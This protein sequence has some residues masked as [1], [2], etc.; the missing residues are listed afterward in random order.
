MRIVS[1]RDN[2]V[3]RVL[4]TSSMIR[5][6]VGLANP[7]AQYAQT[8]HNAGAWFVQAVADRYA[9]TFQLHKKSNGRL[10]SVS[11]EGHDCWLFIPNTYMNDSGQPVRA[12]AQFYRLPPQA[13]LIAYDEL[14]LAPGTVRL[15]VD[16]GDGGHNGLKS[17]IQH[18]G[19][20]QF[21]RLRF[22][23]GH[24]GIRAAVPPY[25]LHTPS[26]EER[27]AI[28]QA[29]DRAV[30]ALPALLSGDYDAVK[31]SLKG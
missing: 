22:G 10:A 24:P 21:A 1:A 4:P 11:I 31:R 25:V 2:A 15:K 19:T 23:I 6:L 28:D 8:R 29:V 14:D 26:R 20:R 18:T 16:G 17:V 12:L 9:G 30:Q 3:D 5:V 7:G 27:Q 13:L